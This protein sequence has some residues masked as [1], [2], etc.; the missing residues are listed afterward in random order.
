[1]SILIAYDGSEDARAAIEYAAGH[2]RQEPVTI[3]SVWEPFLVQLRR[4]PLADVA[5]L[6]PQ[7]SEEEMRALAER[8]AEEGAELARAAGLTEVIARAEVGSEAVW[9]TIVEVADE[10]DASVIVTGSRGLNVV[11]SMLLGSVSNHVLH[12][13][14]RPTLVIPRKY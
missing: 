3:L 6:A 1:M 11:K 10:I 7:R 13:A 5:L 12:H 8:N 9:R 14:S 4:Y 2:L